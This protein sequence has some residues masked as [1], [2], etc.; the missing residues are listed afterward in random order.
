MKNTALL[1][2]SNA[3][4]SI[5]SLKRI[6]FIGNYSPAQCGIATF[7]TDLLENLDSQNPEITCIAVPV[8]D[9]SVRFGHSEHVRF[10]ID[11]HD[12]NS[13]NEAAYF[14][15]MNNVDLVCLQHEY[16]LFGGEM[17][18]YIL[19]LLRDLHMPIVTTLHSILREP[20]DDQLEILQELAGRSDRVIAMTRKGISFLTDIYDV[21]RHKIDL[22]PHGIHSV[23]FADPNFYK[24]QLNVEGRQVLMTFGLLS[25]NKGIEY[26]IQ[27]L[28]EIKESYPDMVYIILGATHPNVLEHE[29]DIYRE[30]LQN[31]SRELG[32]EKHVIFQ[33]QFVPRDRLIDSISAADIYITPY[34]SVDQIVSGS[35]SYAVG[36]G[37]PVISTGYWHAEELLAEGRGIIVPFRDSGAI[38]EK[39]CY[40]LGNEVARHAIRKRAYLKSRDM[41]W[42]TVAEHYLQSFIH[43]KEIRFDHPRPS[44]R[45]QVPEAPPA[46]LPTLNLDHLGQLTNTRGLLQHAIFSVPR[47][48]HGYAT[49]DNA[50]ALIT[51]VLLEKNQL[52]GKTCRKLASR[53]LAFL[54]YAYNK[55]KG[56]FRNILSYDG[57]WLDDSGSDDSH[58]RAVWALGTVLGRSKT[59]E[60]VGVADLLFEQALPAAQKL[61]SPRAI[62]F[63]LHGLYEYLKTFPGDRKVAD[64]RETLVAR[65]V[66]GYEEFHTDEWCWFEDVL[67][68]CNAKLPH[69]LLLCGPSLE[70]E[71]LTSIALESLEWLVDLTNSEDGHFIPIGNNGFYT[72]GQPRARFDQQPVEAYTMVSACVEAYNTT[73]DN[74]WLE[75][76]Q[77]AF[78]WF[79]G[80]NDLN[81]SIYNPRTGGCH[82]GLQPDGVNQN[83]GAEAALSFLMALVEMG[84]VVSPVPTGTGTQTTEPGVM[85]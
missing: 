73:G 74:K 63:T 78:Q 45:K 11:K 27:A 71:R 62:A 46:G 80:R 37:K 24:D 6:A 3:Q 31:I 72:R 41:V 67:A 32:V 14:L 81:L 26:V 20:T 21:P 25:S 61:R 23:Y 57:Q 22:I 29:G 60:F 75:N 12:L 54:W 76:A 9:G 42:S 10:V 82:D 4:S 39:V 33:N 18:K 43:S 1:D 38:A 17:G 2:S 7:T 49:D 69:A 28:P 47:Y 70:D 51:T 13:Y 34:L 35:L 16:G 68:Y 79:L 48:D 56:R 19:E 77:R 5:Q 36:A 8:T 64:I 83:E 85:V 65:L 44:S 53:Y 84:S 52:H 55:K 66:A 30:S 40:L 59:K 15:N 50:R 58:G